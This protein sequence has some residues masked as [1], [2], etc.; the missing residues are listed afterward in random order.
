MQAGRPPPQKNQDCGIRAIFRVISSC[1]SLEKA[2]L[3]C[4]DVARLGVAGSAGAI[5]RR[6]DQRTLDR[7]RWILRVVDQLS[8]LQQMARGKGAGVE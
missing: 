7:C 2:A 8:F 5:S 6:A 3:G 4:G 1:E